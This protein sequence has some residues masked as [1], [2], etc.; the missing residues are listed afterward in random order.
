[1]SITDVPSVSSLALDLV[2]LRHKRRESALTQLVAAAEAKGIVRDGDILM[3]SLLRALRAGGC[4]VGKGFAAPHLRSFAVKRP[5]LLVG[6]SERGVE[7]GA[8]DGTPAQVVTLVLS[9]S[10]TPAMLHV[11]R[12]ASVVHA[13]RLQRTRQRLLEADAAGAAA[14]LSGG[15]A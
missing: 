9:P 7:W 4:A 6:R 11:E 2:E 10:A 12:V 13:L 8:A 14:L 1:M 5:A 15:G 3:A